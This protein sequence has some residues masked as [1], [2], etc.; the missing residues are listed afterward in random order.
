MC[1]IV[2]VS[3]SIYKPEAD[4]FQDLLVFSQVRGPH[5][6]GVAS[7]GRGKDDI[8]LCKQVGRP[9]E[10]IDFDKRYDKAVSYGRKFILGHNRYATQG[11]ITRKNAHP[12]L[13]SNIV[14]C[15]NG[16]VSE[17]Q[18]KGL[19]KSPDDYGTDSECILANIN[20][21]PLKD[22]IGEIDGAWALVWYDNRDGTLNFLRNFQRDLYYTYSLDRQAIFW[23]S[24]T[25][26]LES[27]L[28]RNNV[29]FKELHDVP[30][31]KHLRWVIP[32]INK[33]FSAPTAVEVKAK[34]YVY[35]GHGARFQNSKGYYNVGS[36][37]SDETFGGGDWNWSRGKNSFQGA[38]DASKS[39][40]GTGK[41]SGGNESIPVTGVN[42]P[43]NGPDPK[44]TQLRLVHNTDKP[45]KDFSDPK[46]LH[47][48]GQGYL[49]R[50]KNRQV[51]RGYRG[52]LLDK[53]LFDKLTKEGCVWCQET[54]LWG[55]PIRF[56]RRDQHLCLECNKDPEVVKAAQDS[57]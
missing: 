54:A 50:N 56:I 35:K 24:E 22:V 26:F 21:Y 41:N 8:V 36:D 29:K 34:E 27:A 53:S 14:G 20:D 48:D 10:L 25:G 42:G 55:R 44:T 7:V 37:D 39:D 28:H 3:G 46:D 13:F 52:E 1:G 5:S 33:P 11:K 45:V 49:T 40:G 2:G 4:A 31:N 23:A 43:V 47:M 51:Y 38:D 6:T 18:L 30:A 32:E 57:A 9:N 16:T 15:H 19:K 17:F 12:F